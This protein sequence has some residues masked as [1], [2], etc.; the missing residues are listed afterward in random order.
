MFVKNSS[1]RAAPM[2]A[3]ARN[4]RQDRS[5]SRVAQNAGRRSVVQVAADER[6][7]V[8]HILE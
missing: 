2:T 7:V 1:M 3:A 5:G 6:E 4:G 8:R